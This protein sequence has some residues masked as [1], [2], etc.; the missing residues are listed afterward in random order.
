MGRHYPGTESLTTTGTWDILPQTE[1]S[2][3]GG[4]LFGFIPIGVEKKRGVIHGTEQAGGQQGPAFLDILLFPLRIFGFGGGG[5][6]SNIVEQAALYNAIENLPGADAI[7]APRWH[8]KVENYF[9]FKRV[10]ATVK[11]KGVR[12]N[13]TTQQ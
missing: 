5:D 3:S 13:V 4:I 9:I 2:S 7:M 10:E 8:M 6:A 1:G 12:Y 11:G